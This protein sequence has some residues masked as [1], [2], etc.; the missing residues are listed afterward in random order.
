M[1]K[2]LFPF[3]SI[4]VMS[5]KPVSNHHFSYRHSFDDSRWLTLFRRSEKNAWKDL[6]IFHGKGNSE[7]EPLSSYRLSAYTSLL[8]WMC[9]STTYGHQCEVTTRLEKNH[10]QVL[11]SGILLWIISDVWVISLWRWNVTCPTL[12]WMDRII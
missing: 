3:L 6:S 1:E 12:S 7:E 11:D 9:P 2:D 10:T 4:F 5:I 8:E